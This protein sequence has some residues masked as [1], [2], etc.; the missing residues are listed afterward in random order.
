MESDHDDIRKELEEMICKYRELIARLK[1][2]RDPGVCNTE[3]RVTCKPG[4]YC[5]VGEYDRETG[6]VT[7]LSGRTNLGEKDLHFQK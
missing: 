5:D 6:K 3:W 1:E 4:S 2:R 7:C